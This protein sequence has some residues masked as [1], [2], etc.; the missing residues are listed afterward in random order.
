MIIASNQYYSVYH[1]Y[2]FNLLY[3]YLILILGTLIYGKEELFR[4]SKY[5]IN[6]FMQF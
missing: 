1:L 3:F 2:F 4:L 5:N 6:L